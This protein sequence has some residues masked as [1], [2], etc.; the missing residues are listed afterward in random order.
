MGFEQHRANFGKGLAERQFAEAYGAQQQFDTVRYGDDQQGEAEQA[1]QRET[2]LAEQRLDVGGGRRGQQPRASRGRAHSGGEHDQPERGDGGA[3]GFSHDAAPSLY[4]ETV[5]AFGLVTVE[6]D[7]APDD[8]VAA[9]CQR[10]QAHFHQ[11]AVRRIHRRLGGFDALALPA[12]H[13]A[14]AERRPD[15]TAEP[16]LDRGRRRDRGAGRGLGAL[17]HGKGG[18][19]ARPGGEQGAR[20]QARI[21]ISE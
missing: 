7:D 3:Y 18:G 19:K 1:P 14:A 9:R 15:R 4:G 8:L 20:E 12:A 2:Q 5:F 11:L 6:R 10:R 16:E 13:P 21:H 17:Q